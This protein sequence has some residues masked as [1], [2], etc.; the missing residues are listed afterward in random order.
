MLEKRKCILLLYMKEA[1]VDSA[2][3]TV[4]TLCLQKRKKINSRS[5]V[6]TVKIYL[7]LFHFQ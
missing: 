4:H 5:S 1:E 3:C 6:S 7:I 2:H